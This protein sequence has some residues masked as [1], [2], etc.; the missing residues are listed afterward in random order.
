MEKVLLI[1]R[2]RN[3]AIKIVFILSIKHLAMVINYWKLKLKLK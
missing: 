2:T 3:E 1:F